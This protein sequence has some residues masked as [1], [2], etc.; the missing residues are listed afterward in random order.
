MSAVL[1][2]SSPWTCAKDA[3]LALS[4]GTPASSDPPRGARCRL[5]SGPPASSP[6]GG[7]VTDRADRSTVPRAVAGEDAVVWRTRLLR[8]A[9]SAATFPLPAVQD[10]SPLLR[11]AAT[12]P[13]PTATSRTNSPASCSIMM[14]AKYSG[15][16]AR[17]ASPAGTPSPRSPHALRKGTGQAGALVLHQ[18]CQLSELWL[19]P[20]RAATR[21][22]TG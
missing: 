10:P 14:Y 16:L 5:I 20:A 13:A 11:P 2:Q 6:Q 4:A 8:K 22:P 3:D 1:P 12:A 9:L 7:P 15:W 19:S 17:P 18:A 21:R